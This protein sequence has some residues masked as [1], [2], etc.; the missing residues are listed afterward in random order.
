MNKNQSIDTLLFNVINVLVVVTSNNIYGISN[1]KSQKIIN[2]NR[3]T[4]GYRLSVWNCVVG[5][6]KKAYHPNL[7]KLNSF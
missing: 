5:W 3:R 7:M 2:G 1:N 6:F 4:L